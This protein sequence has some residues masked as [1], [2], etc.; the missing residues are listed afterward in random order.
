MDD[1]VR[2]GRIRMA[3]YP[4]TYAKDARTGALSGWTI[5]VIRALGERLGVDGQPVE[6]RTPPEAVAGLLSGDCDAAILGIQTERA[7]QVDFTPPLVELDYAVLVPAGISAR[8]LADLDRPGVR[9]AAVRG[10]ASTLELERQ[11]GNAEPVYADMLGPAFDLLRRGEADAFASVREI[12]LRS[13]ERLP[14]SRVLDDRYGSNLI[15]LAV[16]K[17]RAD[18]LCRLAA[19]VEEVKASGLVQQGLDR[20]GWRGA[21]VAPPAA[22]A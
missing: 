19:F 21:R 14:G 13:G 6:R 5:D 17:G 16:P 20:T 2:S 18:R 7:A 22:S 9:I 1:I 15:G 3:L 4:P 8:R 11:L 10:H 12:V